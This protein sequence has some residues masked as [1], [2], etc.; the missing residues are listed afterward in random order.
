MYIEYWSREEIE[1]YCENPDLLIA[2]A[3][4]L[5]GNVIRDLFLQSLNRITIMLKQ[6]V[7]SP[8]RNSKSP[9]H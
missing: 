1:E 5:R 2:K 3:N 7:R 8:Y 9:N 4:E 6:L